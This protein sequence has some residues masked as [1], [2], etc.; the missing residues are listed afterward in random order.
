MK[1]WKGKNPKRKTEEAR[2]ELCDLCAATF[3]ESEATRGY[4]PDPFS[5]NSDNEWFD[6]LRLVPACSEPHCAVV[7]EFHRHRPFTYEELWAAEVSGP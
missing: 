1:R 2:L 4:V 5:V 3:P 6:G 7:R